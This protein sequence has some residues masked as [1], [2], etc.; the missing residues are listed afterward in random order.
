VKTIA[1]LVYGDKP[2][3]QLEL[4]Y[5]ILS[6][7]HF[8]RNERSAIRIVLVTEATM[9]RDDLPVEHLF[10]TRTDLDQW[11]GNGG[12]YHAAKIHAL[13]HVLNR[14]EGPVVLIDTDTCFKLSPSAMFERISEGSS[15]MHTREGLLRDLSCWHPL[16]EKIRGPIAGY[17]VGP[18][19]PIYNSGVVGV[20]QSA[21]SFLKEA[22]ELMTELRSTHPVFNIEQFSFATV[23]KRYTRLNVCPDIVWHY[24]GPV[25]RF[26]HVQT[27]AMFPHF[28]KEL[29]DSHVGRL[30]TIGYP[31]KR[32]VD[33][34]RAR[35]KQLLR[36]G[37]P[38]Y[39]FS[40]L[41][42]LSALS[43]PDPIMAKAWASTAVDAIKAIN[44]DPQ[45]VRE[46][47]PALKSIPFASQGWLDLE[48]SGA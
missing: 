12:Y 8:L 21:R 23:L 19:S 32:K 45:L 41:A 3:Y 42:Y 36:L 33:Q 16:L 39:R 6:A 15:L 26:C 44:L 46:D 25:R 31:P 2:E 34:L 18:L 14:S 7:A 29:F 10:F 20:P 43:N 4:T 24:W 40:Y 1:Y 13:M 37:G 48:T 9:R 28:S 27:A 47:F 22:L 30:P 17:D 11:T 35:I 38:E 5:S